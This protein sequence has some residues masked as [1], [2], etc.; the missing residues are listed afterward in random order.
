MSAGCGAQR[1]AFVD[2]M[3]VRCHLAA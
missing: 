1:F 3:V 2:L